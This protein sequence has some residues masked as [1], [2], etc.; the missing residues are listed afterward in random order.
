MLNSASG[1]LVK[2]VNKEI[3]FW[4]SYIQYIEIIKSCLYQHKL[5]DLFQF[6]ICLTSIPGTLFA[7]TQKKY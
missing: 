3:L 2:H 6:L 4:N 7:I 5:Y 1:A